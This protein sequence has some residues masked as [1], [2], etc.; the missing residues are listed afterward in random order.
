VGSA[1]DTPQTG[2]QGIAITDHQRAVVAPAPVP[3]VHATDVPLLPQGLNALK[4]TA[5]TV[6]ADLR[7]ASLNRDGGCDAAR[8]RTGEFPAGLIPTITESPRQRKTAERGRKRR[9]DAAGRAWRIRAER[10]LARKDTCQRWWLRVERLQRR[11][12]MTWLASRR[13]A[14][15]TGEPCR[16]AAVHAAG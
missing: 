1:G 11:S 16:T 7:G 8:H 6:A 10:T 5:T 14:L 4:Q 9:V 2:G 13:A 15:A 12:G 3:P